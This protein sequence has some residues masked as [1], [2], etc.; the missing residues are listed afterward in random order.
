MKIGRWTAAAV[1]LALAACAG[2]SVSAVR[3][4]LG[5][6][7]EPGAKTGAPVPLHADPNAKVIL[8][9]AAGLPA[10]SFL[11]AQASRGAELYRTRC[12]SCHAPGELIGQRFVDEWNNRR[13]YDLYALVRATMPLSNPGSMKDQEYLELSAYLLQANHHAP[14]RPDSL[15][16]DTA[17]LR[18]VKISVSAP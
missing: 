8:S 15:A 16:A 18:R 11:P 2:A 12:S 6:M 10:A 14:L 17:A 13:V 4:P 5:A 7:L 3:T 9:S 1:A